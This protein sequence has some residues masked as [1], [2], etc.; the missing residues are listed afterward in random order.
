VSGRKNEF[1]NAANPFDEFLLIQ[2]EG[3]TKRSGHHGYPKHAPHIE[4]AL[5]MLGGIALIV[6]DL[7][8]GARLVLKL[9]SY[10]DPRD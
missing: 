1:P 5:C 3:S 8:S 6:T 2:S 10:L 9:F 7:S 4:R